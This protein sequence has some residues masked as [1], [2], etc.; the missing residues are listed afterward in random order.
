MTAQSTI[1]PKTKAGAAPMQTQ[2]I[3]RKLR[4]EL[5]AYLSEP[6]IAK[7]TKACD[8]SV[9]A[10]RGQ[11][12]ASGEPFVHHPIQV[13]MLMAK[14]HLDAE[15]ITAGILHDVIEDTPI[16]R[17]TLEI[18]FGVPVAD[19][20]DG[21][22]KIDRLERHSSPR[23]AQALSLQKM[24]L[25]LTRDLRVILVKLV[26][27]LHNVRTL[28]SLPPKRRR[29]IARE[30]LEV[31]ATIA[32]RLGMDK[33]RRELEDRSFQYLFPMRSRVLGEKLDSLSARHHKQLKQMRG[34]ICE[35]LDAAGIRYMLEI[36]NKSAYSVYHKMAQKHLPF[37][38]VTDIFGFRIVVDTV[39]DCYRTMGILHNLYKPVPGKFKDYIALP[40]NNGY[41]SLHTVLFGPN[42]IYVETQIRTHDMDSVADN[43]IASHHL[44]KIGE[45]VDSTALIKAREWV[46][47]LTELHEQTDDSESFVAGVKLNL[48]PNEVYVFT[49]KG[50]ISELPRGSTVLDFAFT[51]HTT[52]GLTCRAARINNRT[53]AISEKLKTGQ[54][55]EILTS[56]QTRPDPNWLSFLV[57]A[58]ARTVVKHH[59]KKMRKTDAEKLG[60]RLLAQALKKH[61]GRLSDVG[62]TQRRRLL[63]RYDLAAMNELY[64]SLG[65][66]ENASHLIAAQLLEK[67]ILDKQNA[68]VITLGETDGLAISYG[69]CCYPIP[70]DQAFGVLR[71]GHGFTVHRQRCR[72]IKGKHRRQMFPVQWPDKGEEE[73]PAAIR[74]EARHERGVLATI[75]D[76]IAAANSNIEHV[77]FEGEGGPVARLLF[78]LS[79][80]DRAH[81]DKVM[82]RL[83]NSFKEIKVVRVGQNARKETLEQPGEDD[84]EN[85]FNA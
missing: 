80:T 32:H 85:Y 36:R 25:A 61:G 33:F 52:V 10:H 9:K 41:Q 21:V 66:G 72:S 3:V 64:R 38:A 14:L 43:G 70:G 2:A 81:L 62:A 37:S 77:H 51:V 47:N 83:R 7:I 6:D 44:Y 53:C 58:K 4:T 71:P 40:K 12:R 75:A 54:T 56:P 16:T 18:E 84:E 67:N 17:E 50:R 68:Q 59:L 82:R 13:A 30:T 1:L 46:S 69:H 79:V 29:R 74:V 5:A 20:V 57:T 8:F 24:I 39:D 23:E 31:Y 34:A 73:Y 22:S 27:R 49:P 45:S 11:F 78:V 60:K 76:K 55:V 42:R 63:K 35:A 48:F 15:A 26:D 65:T 28:G 19:I